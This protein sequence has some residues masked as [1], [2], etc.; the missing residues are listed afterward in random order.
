MGADATA[1]VCTAGVWT[2][3]ASGAGCWGAAWVA[4][5]GT[6]EAGWA[7]TETTGWG[8]G[9]AAGCTA[10][11]AGVAVAAESRDWAGGCVSVGWGS[12]AGSYEGKPLSSINKRRC[13]GRRIR[14]ST[15]GGGLRAATSDVAGTRLNGDVSVDTVRL[16]KALREQTWR[17][18]Q[19]QRGQAA[20]T[21]TS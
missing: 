12:T 11:T 8:A 13:M 9:A 5:V 2:G 4:G 20:M 1:G 19:A 10:A 7:A 15:A 17:S 16:A 21:A 3:A 6:G 14:T 18:V